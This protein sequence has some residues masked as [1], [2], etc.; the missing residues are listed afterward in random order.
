VPAAASSP[1]QLAQVN[2]MHAK[3]PLDSG[4]MRGFVAE[5]EPLNALA[6]RSEGFLWRLQT[7]DGDATAIRA[8]PDDL[9]LINLSVWQSREHLWNYAYASQHL[10]IL[11]RRREWVSRIAD[12]ALALWW[13]EAGH[14]PTVDEARHHLDLLRQHGPTPAAFTFRQSYP[15][16]TSGSP[17]PEGANSAAPGPAAVTAPRNP[18]PARRN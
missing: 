18:G 17:S 8:F 15:P 10:D 9:T 13:V 14:L 7:E 1:F 12:V 3:A 6:E 16:P 4:A 11:R 5:L 2:V